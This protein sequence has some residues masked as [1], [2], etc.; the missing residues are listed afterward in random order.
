MN[1]L[2]RVE[3]V[4][5]A[6]FITD[7]QDLSTVRG[8]G[9]LLL[10]AAVEVERMLQ[11]LHYTVKPI[12]QG[13]SIGLF[14]IDTDA[15]TAEKV[16]DAVA[17]GLEKWLP[18]ATFVVDVCETANDGPT[19]RAMLVAQNRWRQMQAPSVVYPSLHTPALQ[20]ELCDIDKVRPV[21]VHDPSRAAKDANKAWQSASTSYRRE[22]GR[23]KK[24]SFYS[25]EIGR[26]GA[27]ERPD[28]RYTQDFDDLCGDSA[29]WGNLRDKMAVLHLDG[30]KFT[31]FATDPNL[32]TETAL[33]DFSHG[34]RKEQAR[35]LCALIQRISPDPADRTRDD[36]DWMNAGR[37]RLE[38]LLWG[39][40]EITWVFPAWKGWEL[41]QF[42]F[43]TAK[44]KHSW[45]PNPAPLTYTAGLV[46]CHKKAPIHTVTALAR[47]LVGRAKQ[48]A[49]TKDENSEEGEKIQGAQADKDKAGPNRFLYQVLESFDYIEKVDEA[50][51]PF[52]LP[53]T[54][55]RTI[56]DAMPAIRASVSR[57]Q[58]H[59]LLRAL[60]AAPD[61]AAAIATAV[62]NDLGQNSAGSADAPVA[63]RAIDTLRKTTIIKG[64]TP[65]GIYAW[66]HIGELWDYVAP[67]KLGVTH[68]RDDA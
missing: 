23:E 48:A 27:P 16:R 10:D 51:D 63:L 19:P 57:K 50:Y 24:Q 9:L 17:A 49:D 12:V 30:N 66:R 55:M 45:N 54:A 20:K 62:R 52:V 43:E 21:A 53:A 8:A 44:P 25:H 5:Q 60:A 13:A 7:T 14:R 3:G 1:V 40:D 59:N 11:D 35:I 68:R 38:T 15:E 32:G 29:H 2:L 56:T 34:L 28:L 61:I 65:V 18:H 22:V 4:N 33:G 39:G 31:A 64:G 36:P 42:F 46:F 58:L 41:L 47:D 6:N 37:V 26:V 67:E